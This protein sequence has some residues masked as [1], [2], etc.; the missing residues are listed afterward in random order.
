M[1]T[2]RCISIHIQAAYKYIQI[3]LTLIKAPEHHVTP[4]CHLQYL[5]LSTDLSCTSDISL[6]VSI[7]QKMNQPIYIHNT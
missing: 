4:V 6:S 2:D 5:R 1:Y 3:Q 7:R